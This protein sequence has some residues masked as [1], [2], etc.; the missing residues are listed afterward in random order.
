MRQ[1]LAI[2]GGGFMMEDAVSPIDAHICGL[3]GKKNPRVCFIPTPSGDLPAHLDKFHSAYKALGAKTT[4]LTLFRK[5]DDG[6]LPLNEL[7]EQ[8]LQQDV[9]Y[10]GGGNTKSALAVWREWGVDVALRAAWNS[11]VLLAGMSAGAMC[12]FESGITDS[13]G[14]A[15]YKS[16][17]CLGLL[18]GACSVHFTSDA[19]RRLS[20]HNV[21]KSEKVAT[22]I[23]I[24][25]Y[26]AV[27]YKD[28][29]VDHV[30]SWHEGATAYNVTSTEDTP[31][32][33]GLA[34]TTIVNAARRFT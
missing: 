13:F 9:I 34:F 31:R 11:G 10:V 22:S 23:A 27:L 25:D 4:H 7:A 8:L 1:I 17:P 16:L 2:G 3:I 6:S 30:L 19:K 21:M 5:S 15:V 20:L 29:Q 26:A 24:D 33:N 14:G 18:P 28:T 32:E 12:W